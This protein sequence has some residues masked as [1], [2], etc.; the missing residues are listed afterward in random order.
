MIGAGTMEQL[1]ETDFG[2]PLHALVIP[3]DM[4]FLEMEMVRT[5]AVEGEGLEG[6]RGE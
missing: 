1:L 4:H 5:F 3:G 2:P 6:L